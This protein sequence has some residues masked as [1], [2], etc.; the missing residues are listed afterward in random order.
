V[1]GAAGAAVALVMHARNPAAHTPPAGPTIPVPPGP[2]PLFLAG[3]PGAAPGAGPRPSLR[4]P[5]AR[6]GPPGPL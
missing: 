3:D 5:S 6:P 1:L 2:A 4:A